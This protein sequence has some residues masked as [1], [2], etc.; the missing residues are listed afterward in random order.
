MAWFAVSLHMPPREYWAM[1][2]E[3]STAIVDEWNRQQ[4]KA[5]EASK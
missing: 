4:K 3:E 5:E 1:T 2:A